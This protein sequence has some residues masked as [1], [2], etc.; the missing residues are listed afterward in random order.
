L[1]EKFGAASNLAIEANTTAFLKCL[2]VKEILGLKTRFLLGDFNKYLAECTQTFDVVLACG[3]LYHQDDP[4]DLIERM[5][6][7][8]DRI[9]VWTQFYDRESLAEFNPALLR[10]FGDMPVVKEFHG[11]RI[12]LRDRFR[13]EA[14]MRSRFTGLG[15]RRSR[16]LT[17]QGIVTA[18]EALGYRIET[19]LVDPRH[20]N[21]PAITFVASRDD[22]GAFPAD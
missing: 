15:H 20:G 13:Q 21:G 6:K 5:T 2:I 14:R 18:F 10:L 22:K 19:I 4:L 12:E 11:R 8:A 16:W 7:V 17:H 3:V 1:V 9:C